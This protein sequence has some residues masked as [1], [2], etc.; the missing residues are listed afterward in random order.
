[1]LDFGCIKSPIFYMGN[2]FDLLPQL[3]PYFPDNVD[4][5]YDLFGG[6]GCISGNVCAN[7]IV[8]NEIDE[9][10][11]NLY[12]IFTK[13]TY[14]DLIAYIKTQIKKYGLN[15]EG[16]D[17]LPTDKVI[18]DTRKYYNKKYLAFRRA[19]NLSNKDDRMLYTLTLFSFGNLV[20]FNSKG[21][22]NMPYGDRCFCNK[23]M[24]QIRAW[25][26]MLKNKNIQVVCE[27]AFDILAKQTFT[28]EDFIYI[29]PPYSQTMA[30][31]NESSGVNG[32]SVKDDYRLFNILENL[33]NQGIKWGLSNVFENRGKK[34][35][36][37]IEWCLKNNWNV[38]H[39]HFTY[40]SLGKGNSNS[41]EVYICNYKSDADKNTNLEK[42]SI[43]KD[44]F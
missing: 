1:M 24:E 21:D 37:L 25:C 30:T 31:Y 28:K 19:Y 8:Y 27:D 20:R 4:T 40:A 6:S 43:W 5:F 12:K 33:N 11:S 15:M 13:Y 35:T 7:K 2:K 38:Q 34:N 18:K 44:L 36:H 32:W 17:N 39:L 3:M 16:F 26:D 22:F 42:H 9:H 23:H 41:D 10:I 14:E 29:D